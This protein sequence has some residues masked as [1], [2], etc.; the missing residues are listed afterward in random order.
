M[1]GLSVLLPFLLLSL[2]LWAP[3]LG[4]GPCRPWFPGQLSPVLLDSVWNIHQSQGQKNSKV[5]YDSLQCRSP[6]FEAITAQTLQPLPPTA[7]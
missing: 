4:P 5:V 7:H 6:G 2:T 1:G 3:E